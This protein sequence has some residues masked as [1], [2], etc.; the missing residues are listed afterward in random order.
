MP[1]FAKGQMVRCVAN[2]QEPKYVGAVGQVLDIIEL[3]PMYRIAAS[4]AYKKDIGRHLY[5][6]KF[7]GFEA[8][9]C[10]S[11]TCKQPHYPGCFEIEIEPID[12]PDAHMEYEQDEELVAS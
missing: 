1:L 10:A 4:M 2:R 9:F 11:P 7:V 5:E 6:V 8:Q 12:D 3:D